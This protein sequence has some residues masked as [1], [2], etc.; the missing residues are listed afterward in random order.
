MDGARIRTLGKELVGHMASAGYC[1]DYVRS[2]GRLV[3]RLAEAAPDL[4]GWDDAVAWVEATWETES[5]ARQMKV[6]LGHLWR[7]CEEGVLPR[8]GGVAVRHDGPATRDG[9]CPGFAEVIEAY[10]SGPDAEGRAESTVRAVVTGASSLLARLESLGRTSLVEVT[11]DDLI[12]VLTDR[13]GQPAFS[14]GH[15]SHAKTAILG[16]R[17]VDGHE[18][19]A[20]LIP[21]PKQWRKVGDALSSGERDKVREALSDPAADLS[22]RD[23]AMGCLLFYTGMRASDIAALPLRSIDWERDTISIVQRKTSRHL[24]LPLVAEVGNAVFDYVTG[25]R[26][27][28]DDPHVFLSLTWPYGGLKPKS[29]Y[30]VAGKV[31]DAAGVRRGDGDPRGT[32]LFRRSLATAMMGANVDRSVV[33]ATLG[34]ASPA[35]AERYMVAD[36]EGLRRC[37]LDV[38]AFP[39]AE[40]VL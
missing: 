38:S 12:K 8:E 28:S 32:H 35:T 22:Q 19:V 31:L 1:H 39:L 5:S 27:A 14:A 13:S 9:L 26:G 34:H 29:V 21:V 40:G 17:G 15:V 4:E 23:R 2:A 30:R 10:E 18:R 6:L 24:E 16:A 7:L 3:S 33:A 25:E 36:V 20:A 37:A 11:E